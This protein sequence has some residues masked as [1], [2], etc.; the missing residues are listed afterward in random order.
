MPYA[1][2]RHI[3]T[4]GK[5]CNSPA[6][7]GHPFCYFHGKLRQRHRDLNSARPTRPAEVTH[8]I[9]YDPNGYPVPQPLPV[10]QPAFPELDLPLLEDRESVQVAISLI[11]SALARNRV[12]TRRAAV[13]LYGLQLASANASHTTTEPTASHL[14]PSITRGRSGYDLLP[15]SLPADP[16]T[17][18]DPTQIPQQPD[19]TTESAEITA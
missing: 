17:P 8:E 1:L 19:E 11:V 9:V 7:T 16:H 12:E 10:T 4:N 13:M 5:A 15:R 18:H 3:K 14:A 6:L 2:C